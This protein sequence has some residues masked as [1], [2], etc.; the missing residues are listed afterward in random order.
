MDGARHHT[1]DPPVGRPLVGLATV[2]DGSKSVSLLAVRPLVDDGLTLTVA[3][4]DRS[5][6]SVK[7]GCAAAIECH[8]SE[9]ALIDANGREATAVSVRGA[10]GLELARTGVVAVAIA[11]LDSFDVPV[12]LC[13]RNLRQNYFPTNMIMPVCCAN[14]VEE[15]NAPDVHGCL[16]LP[17]WLQDTGSRP[18]SRR[19]TE[20]PQSVPSG[21]QSASC[22]PSP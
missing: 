2:Q 17:E 13:H 1:I 16:P 10:A 19:T 12:N 20:S 18:N 8:V 11:E 4:V 3:L 14:D 6:P 5:R 7:E 21:P 15:R 22:A 9:V